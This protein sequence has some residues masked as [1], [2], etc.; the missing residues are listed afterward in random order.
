M[1]VLKSVR[2]G[3]RG[4]FPFLPTEH[5]ASISAHRLSIPIFPDEPP[6]LCCVS[7]TFCTVRNRAWELMRVWKWLCCNRLWKCFVCG[8][9]AAAGGNNGLGIIF[10]IAI[11]L[12]HK[13]FRPIRGKTGASGVI[14]RLTLLANSLT[15][16]LVLSATRSSCSAGPVLGVLHDDNGVVAALTETKERR[17]APD[18]NRQHRKTHSR[19]GAPEQTRFS[20]S[21]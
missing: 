19:A 7:S 12:S 8:T 18:A 3:T 6:F 5:F 4:G 16:S 10:R 21:F 20:L 17:P 13:M 14:F 1:R 11:R 9:G 15:F 2:H